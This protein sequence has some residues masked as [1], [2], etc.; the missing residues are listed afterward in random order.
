MAAAERTAPQCYPSAVDVGPSLHVGDSRIPV[1]ELALD[2]QELAR[3]TRTVTEVPVG[4]RQRGDAGLRE[5]SAKGVQTHLPG[6]A[7]AMP[8]ITTGGEATP[9]GRYSHPAHVS[10]PEVNET[11]C[12]VNDP[13]R[14]HFRARIATIPSSAGTVPGSSA[15]S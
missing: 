11:S 15:R 1:G 9:V 2:R 12:R 7:Q 10:L 3:L 5:P 6:G 13:C 14:T 4:E 8:R